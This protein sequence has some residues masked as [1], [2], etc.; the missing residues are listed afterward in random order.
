MRLRRA[1]DFGGLG[2]ASVFV[3][4]IVLFAS[5]A[6]CRGIYMTIAS[7]SWHETDAKV[8]AIEFASKNADLRYE[9]M[10][11]KALYSGSTFAFLSAGS[12]PDKDLIEKS[13]RVGDQIKVF[14]NF[15][16]PTE[17]VVLRRHLR[18]EYL[19]EYALIIVLTAFAALRILPKQVRKLRRDA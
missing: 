15:D 13:Y 9:Y 6:L 4:V 16:N 11:G 3:A 17:S 5:S 8:V 7:S 10:V 14:V 2:L 12:I 1:L 18:F 19:W